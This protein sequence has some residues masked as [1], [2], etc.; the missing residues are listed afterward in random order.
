VHH[1]RKTRASDLDRPLPDRGWRYPDRVRFDHDINAEFIH[2][3]LPQG[4]RIR[5]LNAIDSP[6][7]DA[8]RIDGEASEGGA[9]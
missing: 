1:E 9:E 2:M 7:A 5:R 8:H 3:K 4:D 6:N